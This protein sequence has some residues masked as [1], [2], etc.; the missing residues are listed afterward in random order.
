MFSAVLRRED[1]LELSRKMLSLFQAVLFFCSFDPFPGENQPVCTVKKH[2]EEDLSYDLKD[3]PLTVP[4]NCKCREEGSAET[5]TANIRSSYQTLLKKGY[6]S[7]EAKAFI[8]ELLNVTDGDLKR[9][10]IC[11]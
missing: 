10:D 7:D 6:T 9:A 2:I 4:A 3:N 8:K 1:C 11:Q 5:K